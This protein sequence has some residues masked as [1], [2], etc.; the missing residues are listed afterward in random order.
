MGPHGTLLLVTSG[1]QDWRF[2][3]TC[4]LEDPHSSDIWWW[5]LETCSNFFTW[6]P[7]PLIA[8]IWWL[9][10]KHIWFLQAGGTRPTGML[11]SCTCDLTRWDFLVFFFLHVS[12]KRT[13]LHMFL[14]NLVASAQLQSNV[15]WLE[16]F[17][18]Q[19]IR[20]QQYLVLSTIIYTN[21][22]GPLQPTEHEKVLVYYQKTS[23]NVHS[24]GEWSPSHLIRN[25]M[26][27]KFRRKKPP[28][29]PA[30]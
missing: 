22:C 7:P 15:T 3:Q 24:N 27:S 18:V 26:G 1:G 23:L 12:I 25:Q 28:K 8:D 17:R 6:G 19:I 30:Y 9:L 16:M 13:L 4:S 10:E 21:K 20:Q 2:V 11:S 29:I 14:S 5:R